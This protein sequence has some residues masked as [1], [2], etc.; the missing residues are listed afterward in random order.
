ML[1]NIDNEV[2]ELYV[3][4]ESALQ[5]SIERGDMD[6]ANRLETQL[7]NLSISAIGKEVR[8]LE[9]SRKELM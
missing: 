9:E 6:K 1:I 4:L 8:R 7:S 5:K 3:D 2:L